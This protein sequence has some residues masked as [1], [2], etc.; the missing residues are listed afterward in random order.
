MKIKAVVQNNVASVKMLIPHPMETGRRKEQ[1][2]AIVPAHFITEITAT[3][4]GDTVFR[5]ELGP[6]VSKDPYLSF[7]FNGAKAGQMLKVTWVDS[8]GGSGTSEV[9]MT[10]M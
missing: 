3:C 7:Q 8:K 4:G 10:A 6:G 1:N 5:A 9:A 2:G